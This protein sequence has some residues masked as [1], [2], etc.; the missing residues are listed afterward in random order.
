MNVQA[1]ISSNSS[2]GTKRCGMNA[3]SLSG[4]N[5]QAE[6]QQRYTFNL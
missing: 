6:K 2:D 3:R 5:V 1:A 4:C